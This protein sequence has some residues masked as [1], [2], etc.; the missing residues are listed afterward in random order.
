MTNR[1]AITASVTPN[2]VSAEVAETAINRMRSRVTARSSA[3]S[4]TIRMSPI[5]PSTGTTGVIHLSSTPTGSSTC[6][7]A[8]PLAISSTTDGS[9]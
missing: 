5:V 7:S 8:I 2:P 6:R 4:S 1:V 3:P 9:R